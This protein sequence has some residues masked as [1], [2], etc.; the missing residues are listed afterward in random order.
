MYGNKI[1]TKE[2]IGSCGNYLIE[3]FRNMIQEGTSKL[4]DTDFW[5]WEDD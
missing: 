5:K 2:W 3:Y 1:L 4:Q